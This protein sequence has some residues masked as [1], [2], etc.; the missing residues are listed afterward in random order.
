MP[1]NLLSDVKKGG[2]SVSTELL[3][4]QHQIEEKSTQQFYSPLPF[5]LG[6]LMKC[7]EWFRLKPKHRLST[8]II[9]RLNH[10]RTKCLLHIIKIRQ[11]QIRSKKISILAAN[12]GYLTR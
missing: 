3:K 7:D 4:D 8:A 1:R 10:R 11:N 9:L 12:S 5:P 2:S 6:N